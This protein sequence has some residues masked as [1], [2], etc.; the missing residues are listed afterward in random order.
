MDEDKTEYFD[1]LGQP[2]Y[3]RGGAFRLV[4]PAGEKRIEEVA[5]FAQEAQPITKE[6][7]D[8]LCAGGRTDAEPEP[9]AG[10]EPLFLAPA[11]D[12]D[13]A[14][15]QDALVDAIGDSIVDIV[16]ARRRRMGLEPLKE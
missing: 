15:D 16:N 2:A 12:L 4:T 13:D 3:V 1:F 5:R 6:Q 10:R 8:R 9:K 11:S 14:K 7:Y